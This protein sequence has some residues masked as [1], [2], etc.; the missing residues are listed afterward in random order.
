MALRLVRSR[1]TGKGIEAPIFTTISLYRAACYAIPIYKVLPY[2]VIY[3]YIFSVTIT[4][5]ITDNIH[6]HFMCGQ[7]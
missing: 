7:L 1:V 3:I 5:A 4:K 6:I 2:L